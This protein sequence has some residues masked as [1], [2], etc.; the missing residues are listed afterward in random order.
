MSMF[1]EGRCKTHSMLIINRCKTHG[2]F[3]ID[4]R[5]PE[6]RSERL[7]DAEEALRFYAEVCEKTPDCLVI[8]CGKKS[9]A[10]FEKWEKK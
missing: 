8:E 10:Y 1:T 4:S 7:S 3:D 9:R 5:C 6:C 2:V